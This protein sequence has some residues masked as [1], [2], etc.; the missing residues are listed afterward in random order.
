MPHAF[1]RSSLRASAASSANTFDD[2]FLE[3]HSH[4]EPIHKLR[5][6]WT[7]SQAS[8]NIEGPKIGYSS[9]QHRILEKWVCRC[10]TSYLSIQML[11]QKNSSNVNWDVEFNGPKLH[12]Y[13]SLFVYKYKAWKNA[14]PHVIRK[15]QMCNDTSACPQ[16]KPPTELRKHICFGT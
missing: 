5:G 12:S 15:L 16:W 8:D 4:V 11:N 2:E 1:G 10:R 7:A 13:K 6:P 3:F 9:L 14:L